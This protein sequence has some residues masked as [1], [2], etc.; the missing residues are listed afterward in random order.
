MLSHRTAAALLAYSAAFPQKTL[1]PAD[2][3]IP[4]YTA[5]D[6]RSDQTVRRAL[7]FVELDA[8][9]WTVPRLRRSQ[10]VFDLLVFWFAFHHATTDQLYFAVLHIDLGM[11]NE[12]RPATRAM[13]R[14]GL[15][16]NVDDAWL[17]GPLFEARAHARAHPPPP[18][19]RP[20]AAARIRQH[21][22]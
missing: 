16:V 17:A 18:R 4:S 7:K 12:E 14:R 11:V 1:R 10:G 3:C 15:V 19:T 9:A 8:K 22:R 21:V 13:W 6:L 5:F 2:S 20:R